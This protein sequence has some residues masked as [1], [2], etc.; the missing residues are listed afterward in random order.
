MK[1]KI[2]FISEHASP[3]ATLGG[4][5]S[6]GQNVYVAELA[7]HL[8]R[9]GYDIDV[10]TRNDNPTLPEIYYWA[11]GVRVINVIA[12]PVEQIP[13]EA[14]LQYMPD[15]RD[16]MLNFIRDHQL[17]YSLIHANFFMSGLVAAE[18][19]QRLGIP[20][21][22][23]FHAL[24]HVRRIYQG[25]QDKFPPQRIQIEEAVIREA[26]QIIAECPQ[27]SEDLINYYNA[28]PEKLTIIPCGF[29]AEEFYPVDKKLART[30]LDLP[31][32]EKILLQLGR[33]VPRKGVDNVVRSLA[34]LTGK[35]S[36]PVKLVV[37]GG[38][39]DDPD[40]LTNPEIGRLQKIAADA[41]VAHMVRFT[42][43]RNRLMLKYFYSAADI[44]ITTPWYE[45]FGI[46]P[47]E[48]MACGTPVIGANVGGIKYSVVDGKTGL[49]VPPDDPAKLGDAITNMLTNNEMMKSMREQSLKRVNTIFTWAQVSQ[50]V[51]R[52]YESIAQPVLQQASAV[53]ADANRK[54]QAA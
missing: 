42:G 4:V 5:D 22:I 14:L 15:F 35:L 32:N 26:D 46:T 18:L 11:P 33:M 21:V 41:G 20:F 34:T 47:L 49:L 53:A 43:R 40:P 17:D 52:M 39:T 3:L 2:A 7:K 38:E 19:K 50:S 27:D 54:T 51:S 37:V 23:T 28:S 6:G 31:Q 25:D 36:E 16:Y 10:Y 44:F 1:K 48:A 8:S 30:I 12:G 13:K 45:P 29:S 24:G 9:L